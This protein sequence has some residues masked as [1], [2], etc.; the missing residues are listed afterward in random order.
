[1]AGFQAH[2]INNAGVYLDG[3][4]YLAK[5]QEIDLGSLK[6]VMSDFNGLGLIGVV[7]LPDGFEK[8]EGKII[9]NSLYQDAV[10]KIA[11]PFTSISLQCR[12]QIN[13]H[14]SQGR[15]D[16]LPLVTLMTVT[17]KEYQLGSYKP[18]EATTFETPFSA[19]S[20]RQLV[21]GKE[22]VMLDVLS[23]IYRVDGKDQLAKYRSNI[24]Q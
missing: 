12:S 18:R 9:W 6:T 5:A 1:M 8:I 22:T 15:V 2:R 3:N 20:I 13:V 21:G 14:T 4:S 10:S 11:S 16:E 24:G 7:E 19:T 17:F 23:N